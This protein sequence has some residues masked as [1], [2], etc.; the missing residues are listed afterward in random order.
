MSTMFAYKCPR[1][2][3]IPKV[4]ILKVTYTTKVLLH[5][6]YIKKLNCTSLVREDM[7]IKY[8]FI[9]LTILKVKGSGKL[10]CLLKFNNAST[11]V[12]N[13]GNLVIIRLINLF[14]FCEYVI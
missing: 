3:N 9:L 6:S 1:S 13:T 14:I 12:L 10:C 4:A 7:K 11:L 2:E 8:Y 5:Y